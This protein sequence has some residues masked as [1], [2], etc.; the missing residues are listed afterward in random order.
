M[1]EVEKTIT[2]SALDNDFSL[3]GTNEFPIEDLQLAVANGFPAT[4]YDGSTLAKQTSSVGI[5]TDSGDGLISFWIR[6]TRV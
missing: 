1:G 5:G 4:F 3:N 2:L 6:Q